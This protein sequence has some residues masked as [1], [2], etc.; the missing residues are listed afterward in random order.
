[1]TDSDKAEEEVRLMNHSYDGIQEYDNPMPGWWRMMFAGS[2]AFSA[3]YGFYLHIA[4]R[5]ETPDQHYKAQ[6]VE[7]E[8]KRDLRAKA[9]AA[10]ISEASLAKA[11]DDPQLT[12]HG[13]QL[14]QQRCASCHGDK[15][16]GVIGPNLTDQRQI[17]GTTR[18][19]IFDTISNGAPGTAMIA[20]GDQ[21]A[22]SDRM[23]LA[24]YVTTLRGTNVPGKE[25]QGNPVEKFTSP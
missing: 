14:F 18:M 11:A 9:E 17:H 21:L 1:M 20:W 25:P 7:Y 10:N 19:D 16:Q 6:L 22:P 4:N 12:L 24:G 2:I 15:A 3:A 23:A 5:G 13:A 8:G